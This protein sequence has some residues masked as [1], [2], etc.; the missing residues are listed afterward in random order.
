MGLK[1]QL[2]IISMIMACTA[3]ASCKSDVE[4][5]QAPFSSEDKAEIRPQ[6][7]VVFADLPI[8][9]TDFKSSLDNAFP[10]NILTKKSWLSKAACYER[11]GRKICKSALSR[12]KIKR[13]GDIKLAPYDGGIAAYV[14]L[15]AAFTASGQGRAKSVGD[16]VNEKFSLRITFDVKLNEAWQAQVALREATLANDPV[17]V[18]LLGKT[19]NYKKPLE[20]KVKRLVRHLPSRLKSVM[21]GQA[22]QEL[23][24]KS[25]RRLYDPIQI[26]AEPEIWLRGRPVSVSFGGF[27]TENRKITTRLAINTSMS[28][29]VHDRP[30]PLM[31]S[32]LPAL[33]APGSGNQKSHINYSISIGY[34]ELSPAIQKAVVTDEINIGDDENEIFIS[35][36]RAKLYPSGHYLAMELYVETDIKDEWFTQK[37]TLYITGSPWYNAANASLTLNNL[38]ITQPKTTP[39]FFRDGTFL[40]QKSPY[41]ERIGKSVNL[42]LTSRFEKILTHVNGLVNRKVG[43]NLWLTGRF[44]EI[45]VSSISPRNRH[46]QLNLKLRGVLSLRAS[47]PKTTTT[48]PAKMS[49]ASLN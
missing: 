9:L 43:K 26:S 3:L 45:G 32:P 10:E 6:K 47:A 40:F 41:T 38:A 28:T 14:P 8:D 31:P 30:V 27:A 23:A 48:E 36:S 12:V 18:K 29:S 7:T 4:F 1:R 49:S 11:R 16:A 15:K 35:A 37:G 13:A 19:I 5:S 21:E 33:I 25:W 20:N 46:L 44:M 39:K 34:D 17:P 24:S 42:A 22:F 2:S